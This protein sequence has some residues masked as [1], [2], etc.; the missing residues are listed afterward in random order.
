MTGTDLSLDLQPRLTHVAAAELE[1]LRQLLD[2]VELGSDPDERYLAGAG[3]VPYKSAT[4]YSMLRRVG[5]PDANVAVIWAT[6]VPTKIKFFAWLLCN[7]RINS[8]A[9]LLHKNIRKPEDSFCEQCTTV[10]ETDQ[11]I[12]F[13]CPA[14][15]AVWE[16]L[17]INTLHAQVNN[18]WSALH[19]PHL[20][21]SVWPDVLLV[22]LWRVWNSRNRLIFD[23]VV[24]SAKDTLRL[25]AHDLNL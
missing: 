20:P 14:A 12:F 7:G 9:N 21:A 2:P 10:L 3:A 11:H 8:R 13:S 15:I 24:S 23:A 25:A 18:P 6:R 17:E 5:S 16:A 1:S 22:F 4:A 19:P